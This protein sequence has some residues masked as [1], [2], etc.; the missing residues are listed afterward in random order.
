MSLVLL[1]IL[2]VLASPLHAAVDLG[3]YRTATYGAPDHY[4]DLTLSIASPS[5]TGTL[6]DPWNLTRC[7]TEPVD[8]DVIGILPVGAGTP[9]ALAA[10]SSTQTPAFQPTNQG[11]WNGSTCTSKIVWVTKYPAISMTYSSITTNQNRSEFRHAGTDD[12]ADFWGTGGPMFGPNTRNCT[13]YDG[14]FID[15]AQ[16]GFREDAG[17]LHP[18]DSNGTEFRNFVIKGETTDTD[19][20]AVIYRPHNTINT[21]LSNF[22]VKDFVNAPTSNAGRDT[23]NINQLGYFSDTYGD[24]NVTIEHFELDNT[25]GGVFLK[26]TTPGPQFNYGTIQYGIIH[27]N[28]NCLRFNDLHGSSTTIVRNILCYDLYTDSTSPGLAA[29]EAITFDSISTAGRNIDL[30]YITVAKVQTTDINVGGGFLV[31]DLGIGSGVTF[32]NN[33][34][35]LNNGSNGHQVLLLTSLPATMNYNCYTKNG[36]TESYVYNGTQY[37]SFAS[38]QAAISG[39]DANSVEV[40]SVGFTNRA[41]DN[42]RIT[43]GSC[44][45]GSSTGGEMGAYGGTSET[46]GPDIAAAGATSSSTVSGG[47]TF[48]GSVRIQ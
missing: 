26:G 23:D 28:Y 29:G 41:G 11:T 13:V 7:Q 25:G 5:G 34:I 46:I 12:A 18:Y 2:L 45:T 43:S 17:V 16:M 24:R 32:T 15:M 44:A 21:V 37:N 38:W 30:S 8:G 10:P 1:I 33:V 3:E 47:V 20:N 27:N 42:F 31:T 22:K 39:R 9:V 40:A 36:G 35:D 14:F 6:G 48:S 19:S 4:C